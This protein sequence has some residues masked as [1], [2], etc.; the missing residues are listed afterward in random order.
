[1]FTREI[2]TEVDEASCVEQL[3]RDIGVH[4]NSFLSFGVSRNTEDEVRDD[5]NIDEVAAGYLACWVCCWVHPSG[6]PEIRNTRFEMTRTLTR[7][8]ADIRRD[9][10]FNQDASM[11]LKQVIYDD[12]KAS[13]AE[14]YPFNINSIR[15]VRQSPVEPL[16]ETQVRTALTK[17][18]EYASYRLNHRACGNGRRHPVDRSVGCVY[19]PASK[20][21]TNDVF[22]G[23]TARID[24]NHIHGWVRSIGGR[25]G[26]GDFLT[27]RTKLNKENIFVSVP[28][29]VAWFVKKAGELLGTGNIWVPVDRNAAGR[30]V[31]KTEMAMSWGNLDYLL[32]DRGVEKRHWDLL[33]FTPSYLFPKIINRRTD[34]SNRRAWD[35]YERDEY[36]RVTHFFAPLFEEVR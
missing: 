23:N 20:S 8:K 11:W 13:G 22:A 34:K 33:T 3:G 4:S 30:N 25:G 31:S 12:T 15:T 18:C 32:S 35:E 10:E 24:G 6:C 21:P 26:I 36:E 5:G 9:R 14:Y 2:S 19:L 16:P 1:M 28:P 7:M 29:S 17:A 27:V